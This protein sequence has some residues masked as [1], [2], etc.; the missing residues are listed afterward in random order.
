[1]KVRVNTYSGY[2]DA[3][4]PRSFTVNDK[5]FQI[6]KILDTWI[7]ET[8]DRTRSRY[9]KVLTAGG[10][11]HT[12]ARDETSGEWRLVNEKRSSPP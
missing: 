4:K 6:D 1:M 10:S 9:F 11:V 12:L 8:L 3:E 5:D 7:E 2:R